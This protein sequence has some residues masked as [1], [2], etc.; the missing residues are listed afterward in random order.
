VVGYYYYLVLTARFENEPLKSLNYKESQ[1]KKE[2]FL[3]V[4]AFFLE[5]VSFKFS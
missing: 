5:T 1:N 3:Y 2:V 4:V